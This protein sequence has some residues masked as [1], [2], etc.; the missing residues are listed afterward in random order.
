MSYFTRATETAWELLNQ[1]TAGNI[2]TD[3]ANSL[4]VYYKK[5]NPVFSLISTV[6]KSYTIARI[7]AKKPKTD[8][9]N[10]T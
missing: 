3:K 6:T 9:I 2:I 7:Y 10:Y 5:E 4:L 1:P 8:E